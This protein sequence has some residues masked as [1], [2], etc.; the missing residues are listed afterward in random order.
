[1]HPTPNA[2]AGILRTPLGKLVLLGALY[3]S[4]GLPYGF[5]VQALPVLLR[6]RGVPLAFIGASSALALPWALKFLWAPLVDRVGSA[7]FGWRRSWLVPLQAAAVVALLGFALTPPAYA[8]HALVGGVL[9]LNALAATQDIATDGL[10]VRVLRPAERGLGN[11]VQVAGYRV[12]MLLGGGLILSAH[13]RIGWAGSFGLMAAI[14]AL[15]SL[16]VLALSPADDQ[17]PQPAEGGASDAARP[18]ALWRL[19]G[20]GRW[21]A[22]LA[23]Y[24]LGDHF[25]TGMLRPL[26]VDLGWSGAEIG[27]VV[28][29][30]GFGAALVGALA[31]GALVR[32]LGPDR[33]LWVLGGAQALALLCLAPAAAAAVGPDGRFVL[34]VAV[35]AE[36]FFASMATAA[37]FSRMM[38][39][40]RPGSGGA[41]YTLQ[42]SVVVAGNGVGAA[43]SGL[44]A[45]ALGYPAHFALGGMIAVLG[46]IPAVLAAARGGF[47]FP[48][49]AQDASALRG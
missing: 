20:A 42:A 33:A 40:S 7:R 10:A 49:A 32:P 5:F 41:D 37:L 46:I 22:F 45:Q 26:L 13:D 36:H 48:R 16:P 38:D 27:A 3:L 23:L 18:Q 28:G 35:V 6:E 11:G 14:L 30:W 43:L 12:G 31:G 19:P 4:Q 17:P 47:A 8:A 29:V 34:G 1:M 2:S 25:T 39:A 15:A 9:V 24:K 44:S 21:L